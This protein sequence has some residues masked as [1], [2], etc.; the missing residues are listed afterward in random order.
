MSKAIEKSDF[1]LVIRS[2]SMAKGDWS[3]GA[4]QVKSAPRRPWKW[5]QDIVHGLLLE[6]QYSWGFPAGIMT[7]RSGSR[8]NS[9]SS[10]LTD[11]LPLSQRIRMCCSLPPERL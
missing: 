4:A 1:T 8:V 3:T 2:L 10:I 5:H 9:R 7:K 11:P 6:D